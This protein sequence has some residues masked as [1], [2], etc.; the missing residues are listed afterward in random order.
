MLPVVSSVLCRLRLVASSPQIMRITFEM[1]EPAVLRAL[2]SDQ[3]ITAACACVCVLERGSL[4]E[5]RVVVG[6]LP[7]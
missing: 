7:S 1:C 3:L 4:S 5:V 2:V 6:S